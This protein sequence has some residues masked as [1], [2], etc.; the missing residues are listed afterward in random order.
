[1]WLPRSL[2]CLEDVERQNTDDVM[3]EHPPPAGTRSLTWRSFNVAYVDKVYSSCIQ[4]IHRVQDKISQPSSNDIAVDNWSLVR[5]DG[6]A[7]SGQLSIVS[8]T[9]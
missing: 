7:H 4:S 8:S 1:M 3:H 6:C 9:K 2:L 5:F